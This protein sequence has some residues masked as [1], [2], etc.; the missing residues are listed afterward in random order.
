MSLIDISLVM[1]RLSCRRPIF[2]TEADFQHALAWE[3]QKLDFTLDIRLEVPAIYKSQS[4]AFIDLVVRK[5]GITIFIELKYKTI[6][7]SFELGGELF[8]LKNQGAQDQGSYDF[9]KDIAR[10]ESFVDNT[11]NSYGYVIILSNDK[12][13]WSQRTSANPID[14]NFQLLDDHS[15][16]GNLEWASHAGAGSIKG[17]ESPIVLRGSYPV[18]WIGYSTIDFPSPSQF[19]YLSL[20]IAS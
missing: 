12:K 8:S 15:V 10:V 6:K 1:H 16:S 9:L 20:R 7:T 3:L 11:K 4:R 5:G 13:Y 17:R 19:R 2:H 18:R 14:L